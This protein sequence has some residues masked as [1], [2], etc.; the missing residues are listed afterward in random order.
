MSL[1]LSLIETANQVSVIAGGLGGGSDGAGG[2]VS[3]LVRRVIAVVTVIVVAVF[4]VLLAISFVKNKG[5]AEGQKE[6]T[7]IGG[8]FIVVMALILGV[9]GLVSIAARLGGGLFN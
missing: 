1:G 6:I 8:Q 3:G 4:T 7:R 2:A 5:S 9:W